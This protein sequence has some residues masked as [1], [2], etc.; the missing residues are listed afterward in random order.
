VC[1]CVCFVL[2]RTR[3]PQMYLRI[4]AYCESIYEL[5]TYCDS[6]RLGIPMHALAVTV[7]R[8]T[9]MRDVVLGDDYEALEIV[10]LV[11][12]RGYLL[13]FRRHSRDTHA[14]MTSSWRVRRIRCKCTTDEDC[15]YNQLFEILST[16]C[17]RI[18]RDDD[19][20]T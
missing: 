13:F 8:L 12:H 14:R 10:H 15:F 1:V 16:P 20:E 19:L 17:T 7:V 5:T 3:R 2:Q 6:S 4:N 18:N 11:G 9:C